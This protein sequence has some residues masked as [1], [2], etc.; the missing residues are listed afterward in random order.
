MPPDDLNCFLIIQQFPLVV[1]SCFMEFTFF[2]CFVLFEK[3]P[4][5]L[6]LVSVPV[7][8]LL[9]F[10][11]ENAKVTLKKKKK[12]HTMYFSPLRFNSGLNGGGE[13]LEASV[14]RSSVYGEIRAVFNIYCGS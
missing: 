8:L 4:E 12:K 10:A 2:V 14:F 3:W 1:S 7:K 13:N 6:G 11:Q 5:T 9:I